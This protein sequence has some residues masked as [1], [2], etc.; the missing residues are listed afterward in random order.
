MFDLRIV[1]LWLV[2]FVRSR[3]QRLRIVRFWRVAGR[4]ELVKLQP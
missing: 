3:G 1:R 2:N 4:V